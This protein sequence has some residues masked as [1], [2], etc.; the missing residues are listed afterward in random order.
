MK[1]LVYQS[2]PT[3]KFGSH[4]GVLA[5]LLLFSGQV[6]ADDLSTPN[7]LHIEWIE[8]ENFRDASYDDN[9]FSERSRSIVLKDLERWLGKR[10]QSHFKEK[11]HLRLEVTELDLAGDFEPWR[12]SE[13]M[14]IRIIRRIYP[15]YIAFSYKLTSTD[16]SLLAEGEEKLRHD[17]FTRPF[18]SNFENYAYVKE[19]VDDWM[20]RLARKHLQKER[21]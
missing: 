14:D 19:V 18:N 15:A 4:L 16:G 3:R 1:S 7:A 20:S 9:R 5:G 8:P 11:A 13:Y 6:A 12:G 2:K 21:P 17:L 10:A